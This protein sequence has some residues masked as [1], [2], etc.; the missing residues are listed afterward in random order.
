VCICEGTSYDMCVYQ[1][2]FLMCSFVNVFD[3]MCAF[4]EVFY[5]MCA[6]LKEFYLIRRYESI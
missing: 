5:L 3:L 1:S 4:I 2:I 6:C